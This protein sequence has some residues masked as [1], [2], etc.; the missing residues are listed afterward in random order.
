MEG[1]AFTYS[2][3][4]T[5]ADWSW[6]W[7]RELAE[8]LRTEPPASRTLILSGLIDALATHDETL[9]DELKAKIQRKQEELAERR[10]IDNAMPREPD[11]THPK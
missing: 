10:P 6:S 1:R 4:L 5:K 11:S 9:I 7:A 8:D 2:A 3:R